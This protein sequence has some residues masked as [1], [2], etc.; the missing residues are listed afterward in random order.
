MAITIAFLV[1]MNACE[2]NKQ[3]CPTYTYHNSLP[4]KKK[5]V[6]PGEQAPPKQT[7]SKPKSGVMPKMKHTHQKVY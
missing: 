4:E 2:S 6:K 5:D 1:G 3:A 7:S